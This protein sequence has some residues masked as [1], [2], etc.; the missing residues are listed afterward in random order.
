MVVFNKN[1]L[2]VAKMNFSTKIS[3]HVL[4]SIFAFL[5]VSNLFA[6]EKINCIDPDG[7]TY[8]PR[9]LYV[10]VDDNRGI[11][12]YI[13]E[14]GK[15]LIRK[16]ALPNEDFYVFHPTVESSNALYPKDSLQVSLSKCN[17]PDS[18]LTTNNNAVNSGPDS[19]LPYVLLL[20]IL[21]II[22]L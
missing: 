22:P 5:C 6:A 1:L 15:D 13:V 17:N 4:I 11:N 19:L 21:H 2:K 8:D 12:L 10:A 18:L 16:N 3:F 14:D 7:G 20:L 9:C